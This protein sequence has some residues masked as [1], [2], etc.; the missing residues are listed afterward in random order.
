MNEISK[1]FE[2]LYSHFVLRD[3]AAKVLPGLVALA[4]IATAIKTDVSPGLAEALDVPIAVQ[5]VVLYGIGLAAGLLLQFIGMKTGLTRVHVWDDGEGKYSTS[6]SVKKAVKF[7][8]LSEKA[9][10]SLMR[11]RERM[12]VLK[13]MMGNYGIALIVVFVVNLAQAA[14]N[15]AAIS[16]LVIALVA[17]IAALF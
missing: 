12:V 7:I 6:T 8:L 14:C 13:E 4:S 15:Q 11:K 5:L 10:D 9:S 16:H 17:G 2:V 1:F 3:I